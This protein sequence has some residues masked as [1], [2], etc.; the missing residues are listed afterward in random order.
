[1]PIELDTACIYVGVDAANAEVK[2]LLP[3][4]IGR[5]VIELRLDDRDPESTDAAE[6]RLLQAAMDEHVFDLG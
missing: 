5:N 3:R 6:Y 4:D 1:M 2:L